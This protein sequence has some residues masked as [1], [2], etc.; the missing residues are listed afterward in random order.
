MIVSDSQREE[1]FQEFLRLKNDP[2]YYDV[3]F[4]DKS[5]GVSA[6]HRNHKFDSEI[7]AYGIRV[8][9]YEKNVV[10]ILRKKGHLI[11]LESEIA[12]NGIKTPDGYLD[13]LI[14]EIKSTDGHGKWAIKKPPFGGF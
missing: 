6:V 4:D 12:P 1:N 9:E 2:N 14:M 3:T 10:E 11:T 5:G 13:G 8:G 7:G